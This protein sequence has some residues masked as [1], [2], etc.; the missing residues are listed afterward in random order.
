MRRKTIAVLSIILVIAV[1]ILFKHFEVSE[2]V[3]LAALATVST[4]CL[5]YSISKSR[6]K[7]GD[8]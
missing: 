5:S 2:G 1:P 4:I 7:N 3:A 8:S 6:S